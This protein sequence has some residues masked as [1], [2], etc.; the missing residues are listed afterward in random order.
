M[1][2]IE[3]LSALYDAALALAYPH[4][5][6]ACGVSSVEARSD[7]PACAGCWAAA[8]LFTGGETLCWKCGAPAQG[9]APEAAREG[10][11][12]RRCE[13][14]EFTAARSCGI[15]EGA[16]RA[17]VLYLKREPFPSARLVRMLA[18]AQSRPPLDRATVVMP[19]PLHPER[20]RERGFNQAAVL[21][22]A[23]ARARGLRLDEWSL[24]RVSHTER[25]RAGMD[26]RARRETVEGAFKVVRPRLVRDESPLI[27][28][29]VLT[30]GATI[31]A[32][33]AALKGA[34]A[35]EVFVLTL[36]RA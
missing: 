9:A 25:H 28:D 23:L 30:T 14:E 36:A 22:R 33:A 10:V 1:R 8:K 19:V 3:G 34:G 5:C 32:C 24:A 29:D 31:S 12:C 27:V 17:A 15:Y 11:R 7:M 13:A 18:A 16:L 35:C 6:G 21:A 4:A 26:A 20:E 2:I